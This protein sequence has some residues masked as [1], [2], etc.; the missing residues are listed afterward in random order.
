MMIEMFWRVLELARH[1]GIS[2]YCELGIVQR[3]FMTGWD[4]K[5]QQSIHRIIS[6]WQA[7]GKIPNF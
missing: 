1:G 7:R 5:K 4:R 3:S 6:I 2:I